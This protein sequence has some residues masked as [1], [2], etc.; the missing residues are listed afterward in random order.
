MH[1]G[2]LKALEFDRIV[3]AVCRLAQTPP[4]RDQLA[5]LH[6]LRDA[7]DAAAG[8]RSPG[9]RRRTRRGRL[10]G[11]CE[12]SRR[13]KAP[14]RSPQQQWGTERTGGYVLAT[15]AE[16]RTAI[17][18]IA[19]GSPAS[20]ASLFLEPLSTVEINN[21]IVALEQQEQE[22]VRRILLALADAFRSRAA[23]LHHTIDAATALDAPQA[24]AG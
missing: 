15:R 22:E 20:G 7:R 23:E 14:A 16:N 19:H 10:G 13:G 18:G 17:P 1:L 6:P 21:D 2:A 5:R 24:K 9:S 11:P 3:E 12:P 8:R 4:G